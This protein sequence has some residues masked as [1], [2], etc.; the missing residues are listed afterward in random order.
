MNIVRRCHETFWRAVVDS[1]PV[2]DYSF[3]TFVLGDSGMPA[4]AEEVAV[5]ASVDVVVV[6]AV[7]AD[8]VAVDAD[9]TLIVGAVV[10]MLQCSAAVAAAAVMVEF[11]VYSYF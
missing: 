5:V 3:G 4:G 6:G 11:E 1:A 10:H 7:A 9:W 2:L 8:E